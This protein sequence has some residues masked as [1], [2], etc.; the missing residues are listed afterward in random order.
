VIILCHIEAIPNPLHRLKARTTMK[1][2]H[3]P[4]ISR[5]HCIHAVASIAIAGPAVLR[6]DEAAFQKETY[7]Y[8]TLGNIA[9][10]ADVYR[11]AADVIRPVL[12]W[13]HGGALIM[14]SRTGVP[15][16]LV[17]LCKNDGFVLVSIDYRLAPEVKLPVIIEDVKD[18]IAWIR[19]DGPKL[20]HADL[21]KFV[22]AGGSAGG[23]LTM[24]T[25]CVVEPRPTA[26]VAYWG[27]GDVDGEWYAKPSEHYRSAAAL[28]TNEDAYSGMGG[29]VVTGSE[30]GTDQQKAR[31][32]FYLYLRQNGLWPKEVVGFDPATERAKFDPYCPIRNIDNQYPPI[33]M[34]HGTEDTDVPYDQ[35][36]AMAKELSRRGRPHELVTVPGAG[37]GLA[38]GDKQLVADAHAKAAA[39]IRKH[40]K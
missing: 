26:L 32:R 35:S 17:D 20:F 6:A 34:I 11:R 31:S 10:K 5:R 12:V 2:N 22:V 39:F 16:Q 1:T 3:F 13:I 14:G 23:Y 7:T 4:R 38:E 27:Y 25:G 21:Q 18:A 15:S 30:G 37:H 36:A 29:P 33:L 40:L 24:M 9:I 19:R 8:K 28:V